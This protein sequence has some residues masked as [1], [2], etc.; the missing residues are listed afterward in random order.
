MKDSTKKFYLSKDID[1]S[2]HGNWLPFNF[3]GT[4]DGNGYRIKNLSSNKRGLFSRIENATVKNLGL[5]DVYVSVNAANT[6]DYYGV[7]GIAGN[8]STSTIENCYVTGRISGTS[9]VNYS[10]NDCVW[11]VGGLVGYTNDMITFKNCVNLASVDL[12]GGKPSNWSYAGG[13]IGRGMDSVLTNCVNAG[14][15]N[16][17]SQGSNITARAGGVA[18][19]LGGKAT[20]CHNTGKVTASGGNA[21]A[22]DIIGRGGVNAVM[23]NCAYSGGNNYV[24]DFEANFTAKAS[25]KSSATMKKQATYKGFDFK[26][27]WYMDAKINGGYPILQTM[28]SNYNASRPAA[29]KKGGTY[30]KNTEI[31]LSTS[32]KGVIIRYTTNGKAPTSSSTAYSKAIKLTKNT[33]IKAAVFTDDGKIR[34]KVITFK[35]TVK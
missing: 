10:W 28:L 1:L 34:G 3:N 29:D 18:G 9:N 15:I 25:K 4:L 35:Y 2:D 13:I 8:A 16:F 24:G 6:G 12:A 19:Y 5:V 17:T 31:K 33:N 26:K 23:K 22:G 21:V 27:V 30:S 14:K 32:L 7:G 11:N 20:S